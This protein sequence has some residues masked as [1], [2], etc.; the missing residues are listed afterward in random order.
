MKDI[1]N[2]EY[3]IKMS[4]YMINMPFEIIGY[5]LCQLLTF[6]KIIKGQDIKI[7]GSP[8]YGDL[9]EENW[10]KPYLETIEMKK[11]EK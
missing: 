7:W 1:Q 10:K 4:M 2:T 11:R 3:S 9:Y 6:Q 5:F 8:K